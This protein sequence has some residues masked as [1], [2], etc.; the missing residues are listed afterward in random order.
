M[1]FLPADTEP[2]VLMNWIVT[3]DV[4]RPNVVAT[5]HVSILIVQRDV[6]TVERRWRRLNWSGRR[7]I[8]RARAEANPANKTNLD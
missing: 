4:V 3:D 6:I 1:S 5:R 8:C 2:N 7:G